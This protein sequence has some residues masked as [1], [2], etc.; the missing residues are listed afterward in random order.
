MMVP[1]SERDHLPCAHQRVRPGAG[2]GA[3]QRSA[4]CGTLM[5]RLRLVQDPRENRLRDSLVLWQSV[6][7][8]KLLADVNVILFLN[9]CD[10]LKV[11]VA[12]VAADGR[13]LTI[14]AD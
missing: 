10:L 9:K 13:A 7:S 1:R 6:V 2:R 14:W 8:N 5:R 3:W 12:R 4:R 11:R